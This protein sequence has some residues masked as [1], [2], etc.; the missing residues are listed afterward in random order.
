MKYVHKGISKGNQKYTYYDKTIEAN[1]ILKIK[2][3]ENL[4][5]WICILYVSKFN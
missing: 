4:E 1:K 3:E 2:N 5:N